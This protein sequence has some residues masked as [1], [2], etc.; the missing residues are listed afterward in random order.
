MARADPFI[1]CRLDALLVQ[2]VA[3]HIE[4]QPRLAIGNLSAGHG[5]G[6]DRAQQMQAG[7]QAHEAMAIGP[8]EFGLDR[9]AGLRQHRFG[10][11]YMQ[12]VLRRLALAGIDD[13]D[14]AP[15]R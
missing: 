5:T 11:G 14:R 15:V 2:G 1:Q 7:V 12:D 13:R 9:H 6:H 8:V 4:I 10:R 3:R